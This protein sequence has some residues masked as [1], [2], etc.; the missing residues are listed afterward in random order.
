M[1]SNR[2]L[3]WLRSLSFSLRFLIESLFS[4]FLE[5]TSLLSLRL[6]DFSL[7]LFTDEIIF[8]KFSSL[9][10]RFLDLYFTSG[11]L[12]LHFWKNFWLV[13]HVWKLFLFIFTSGRI[14]FIHRQK[15]A[16]RLDPLWPIFFSLKVVVCVNKSLFFMTNSA[17]I[18]LCRLFLV[19]TNAIFA[20]LQKNS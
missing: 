17:A 12:F 5:E 10:I 20:V 16:L 18:C 8:Y 19:L 14:L 13:L 3:R 4:S 7:S 6:K 1:R 9:L 11:R 2:F 15:R